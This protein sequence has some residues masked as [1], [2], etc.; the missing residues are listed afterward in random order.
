MFIFLC[1]ILYNIFNV[2]NQEIKMKPFIGRENEILQ[3][4]SLYKKTTTKLVV[5]KG[6]RRIGKSRLISEFSKLNKESRFLNFTALAPEKGVTNQMQL[7]YFGRQ[8]SRH[9][10]MPPVSFSDWADAFEYLSFNSKKSDIILFD[11]ISWMGLND[12]AFIP[13]LKAFWDEDL[14]QKKH[15]LFIL[16]GSIATWIEDNILNSTA[17]FGRIS[18]TITLDLLSIKESAQL[19]KELGFKGSNLDI[20][21]ILGALGGV[22]WYL[23]QIDATKMGI[24]NIKDLCFIKNGLLVSEFNTM[25]YDLFNGKGSKY[26]K[27]LECLNN[28][29]KTLAQIRDDISYPASGTLS[30]MMNH[31]VVAGFVQKHSMWSIKTGKTSQKSLYR[32]CDAYSRFYLKLIEPNL[33]KIQKNGF[34][35]IKTIPGFDTHIG[36]MVENLLIQNRDI[37]LKSIGISNNETLFDGP[38][39][40]TK[41][42]RTKGC[43]IDYLIQTRSR[44][45]F[46]CEFKFRR[47]ALGFEI[48]DEVKE[49]MKRFVAPKGFAITPVLFHFGEI[50]QTVYEQNYFYKII[51]MNNFIE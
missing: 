48:I 24:D 46:L 20:Y 3:L 1:S 15:I 10:N 5:V 31:L 49:K 30:S 22:P 41:T 45:L 26:R 21:T 18:M 39:V 44:N 14:S 36:L 47:R 27:I 9:L 34:D 6:R 7:D 16:C 35:D 40:Q 51:D 28:A 4:Q 11:E 42:L 43:Q 17:F 13:K 37:L 33:L 25:F 19:L 32:I 12:P 2:H 50:S 23:E 8:L 38:Y 29:P